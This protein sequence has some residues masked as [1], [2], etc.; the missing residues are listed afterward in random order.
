LC[1]NDILLGH[2][3]IKN[4]GDFGR[5]AILWEM[6]NCSDMGEPHVCIDNKTNSSDNAPMHVFQFPESAQQ[7]DN[8]RLFSIHWS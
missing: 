5:S 6:P 4:I 7:C 2:A 3:T 8:Q 1:P